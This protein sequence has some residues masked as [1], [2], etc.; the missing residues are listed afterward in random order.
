MADSEYQKR[1][2]G[3]CTVFEVTP[4]TR[5]KMKFLVGFGVFMVVVGWLA[6]GGFGVFMI[7]I[8]GFSMLFGWFRDPR[9]KAYRSKATF[10]VT[11]SS[12]ETNGRTFNR[13]NIHRLILRNG[14]GGGVRSDYSQEKSLKRLAPIDVAVGLDLESG[15]KTYMLAGG[16][17]GTTA[18]GLL[19]DVNKVIGVETWR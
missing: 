10:R 15:G 6:G 5:P 13:Q 4:A 7:L 8:G 1:Q 14:M 11:P 3:N 9:P 19:Q 17:D 18:F 2:E 12:I 16:M